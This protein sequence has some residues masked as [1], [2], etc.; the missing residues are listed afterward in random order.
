MKL[1]AL[2]FYTSDW[3]ADPGVRSV[4]FAARGLWMDVLCLMSENSRRGYLELNGIPIPLERIARMTGGQIEEVSIL[5]DELEQAGVFSRKEG[6]IYNRRMDRDEEIRQIRK[7]AG[8]LG[9]TYGKLGGR[10]K[11]TANNGKNNGKNK[12]EGVI[13]QRQNKG[14]NN[15]PSSSSSSSSSDIKEEEKKIYGEH[16]L[17]TDDEYQKLIERFG[18]LGTTDYIE[19]MNLYAESKPKKFKEYKSHYATLLNWNRM[20][21]ERGEDIP[22]APPKK[23]IVHIPGVSEADQ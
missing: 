12:T 20:A 15:P 11:K 8:K 10:P 21:K 5:I 3:L 2:Q 18:E 19:R 7:K 4:S 17:L 22:S 1:P 23:I 14:Q 16:V 6:V 9:S 13:L